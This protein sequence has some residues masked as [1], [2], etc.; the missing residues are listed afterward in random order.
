[1]KVK[2]KV[3]APSSTLSKKTQSMSRGMMRT[4][5]AVSLRANVEELFAS[6]DEIGRIPNIARRSKFVKASHK[7]IL[8]ISVS[9]NIA[10]YQKKGKYILRSELE[11]GVRNAI[12]GN[13]MQTIPTR[14]QYQCLRSVRLL[15]SAS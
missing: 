1:V 5:E 9:E 12:L 11:H 15:K 8:R 2:V 6:C 7:R 13:L 10:D 4:S 14:Q 3:L